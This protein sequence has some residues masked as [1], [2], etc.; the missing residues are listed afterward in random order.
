MNREDHWNNIYNTKEH[1]S[2]SWYQITPAT[3]LDVIEKYR[4]P[5]NANIIDIGGGQSF[6]VDQLLKLGYTNITVLDISK[7]AIQRTKERLGNLANNVKWILSDIV[8]FDPE[9]KYDFW[10]DRATFHFLNDKND[11]AAYQARLKTGLNKNG[12]AFIGTF[13]VDG[14][15]KCSGID[16]TQYDEN[17]LPE[18]FDFLEKIECFRIDHTTPSEKNQNFIF[19]IFKHK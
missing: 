3:S 8:S 15:A 7:E 11:I 1:A 19:C 17:S 14:P 5:K 2:V 12:I 10:H 18:R 16:I 4:I 9:E 13:S 6:F